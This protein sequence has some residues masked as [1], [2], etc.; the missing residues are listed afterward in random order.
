MRLLLH[1]TMTGEPV[2]P[3]LSFSSVSWGTGVCQPSS[4][5]AVLPGYIGIDLY[6]YLVPRKYTLTVAEEG[7]RVLAAGV[8]GKPKASTNRD[9]I[10]QIL[11][12]GTGPESLYQRRSILPYPFQPL[13]DSQGYPIKARNTRITGVQYGTMMKRLY[14]QAMTHPGGAIPVT[15]EPDRPGTREKE[16]E[17]VNGKKVQAA[18]EDISNLIGGVEWSWVPQLDE[19]DRLSWAFVTGTDSQPELSSQVKHSWQSGGS[20]P[21]IRNF[22]VEIDPEF[23]N[24]TAIFTG[25]KDDDR[26]MVSVATG[27]DL[28][29]AGIPLIEIWDSSH[30]SVSVQATLDE[31][32]SNTRIDG[33][34]PV[35]YWSFDVRAEQ[36]LTLRHGDWASID[37]YEHWIIPDGSYDRRIIAVSG[38]EQEDWLKV[39]VAGMVSW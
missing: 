30:S 20:D 2:L 7:G 11:L 17:A 35:Q 31:W 18:V 15:W 38:D 33:S 9:G 26:V 5:S 21:S 28:I 32:A 27:S 29:D 39:T 16:W 34:A 12:N 36:A 3:D 24:Q 23:M 22:D 14:Q 37:V 13:I 10:N 4:V 6:P 19:N 1:E 8:L 25:G